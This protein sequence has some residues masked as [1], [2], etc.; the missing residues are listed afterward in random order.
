MAC[1]IIATHYLPCTAF[2]SEFG[3]HDGIFYMERSSP[4]ELKG[5]VVRVLET[6][7]YDLADTTSADYIE[8]YGPQYPP[9]ATS[10]A[11]EIAATLAIVS[12]GADPK[13]VATLSIVLGCAFYGDVVRHRSFLTDM[14]DSIITSIPDESYGWLSNIEKLTLIG[15]DPK[16]FFANLLK[17]P[18]LV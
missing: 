14:H 7:K 18:V 6:V 4:E 17:R 15:S 2:G 3:V 11:Y 12:G 8:L 16:S 10:L 1:L 9:R 5:S 13:K